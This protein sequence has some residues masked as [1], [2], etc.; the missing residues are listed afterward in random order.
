MRRRRPRWR[1][2]LGRVFLVLLL[3][4]GG[5][6]VW[7]LWPLWEMSARFNS[8]AVTLQPSRLYG[9]PLRL[10]VG[11]V[12]E[13]AHLTD[14]L[15]ALGYRAA[16]T[17]EELS[18]GRYL[19]E[20]DRLRVHQR[21]FRTV[22]GPVGSTVLDVRFGASRDGN[23]GRRR[24]RSLHWGN[25]ATDLA[26]FEPPLV[27]SYYG[28]ELQERRPV[29]LQQVSTEL[30]RAVLAAEDDSFFQHSGLSPTGILRAAWVNLAGGEVSQGG[31]TLTQ[32]LVKNLFLTP[33]RTWSRKAREAA[34]AV[35]V[36]ARYDKYA[37]L[38]TYLN[39]IYL[40]RSGPIHLLGVGAASWAFFGKQPAH[41]DLAEAATLAGVIR[42]PANFD[43]RRHPETARQRR[44]IVLGRLVELG[45]VTEDQA[46]AAREEPLVVREQAL[47]AR[48]AP[49]FAAFIEAEAQRRFGLDDLT[50]GGYTLF[51][52][53][54]RHA[55]E[56]AERTVRE[57]LQR[58]EE[59]PEKRRRDGGDGPLQAALVSVDVSSG[60]IRAYVG[61]RD[62]AGSQFDRASQARR[63]AGSTFKPL[64]YATA[65]EGRVVSPSSLVLDEPLE[66]K[67]GDKVWRPE[68]DDGE[69]KGLI[70]AR[71]AVEES[72]NVPTARLALEVGLERIVALARQLG[73]TTPLRPLPSLALGAFE[74]APVELAGVY[75]TLAAG[76]VRHQVH[77]LEK[78]LDGHGQPVPTL[79]GAELAA[80]Q[81]VL[82][83]QS[84]YL[85]THVLQGVF[86]RGT[87]RRVRSELSG[88]LAGKTGTTNGRRDCWF[89][90]Y[91][92]TMATV[93]WVGYDDNSRTRL[94]GST[95]P[96][97]I[98][99][100]YME[101]VR[102]PAGF[103]TFRQPSGIVTAA[104]DP[105]TGQL[106]TDRCPE[107]ITEVFLDGEQPA[108]QCQEH[109]S[110]WR[111]RMNRLFGNDSRPPP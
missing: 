90:G 64:V 6:L 88:S 110:W 100:D 60:A 91:S 47:Q 53:L 96:L 5:A 65:F 22:R 46:T 28:P 59:G 29:T 32:Q 66:Y 19:L 10:E 95:G 31:S 106:A 84:T 37:I 3:A 42:S 99:A 7:L 87:A 27:A 1:R 24:V 63:Q 77:G 80:P 54:D 69:Y 89:A 9:Q 76:G 74:V 109:Y 55:Q 12:Q 2:W 104:I 98:W 62:F 85:M 93:V 49:Y 86:V 103:S 48:R 52:T 44:N 102:N 61:G 20:S 16:T 72:R 71:L 50:D 75:A 17:P 51:T 57:G 34:L 30:T 11:A 14:E 4:L 107:V 38:E 13:I 105:Q 111:S 78:V 67:V 23:P 15:D 73:I 81:R 43:P 39:E 18:A 92:P 35:F 56:T 83:L 41:L 21:S 40:G 68:N 108:E 70:P 25:R 97:P 26:F 82:S 101:S 8:A 58:L 33:E 94:T 36:E 79:E 45:W